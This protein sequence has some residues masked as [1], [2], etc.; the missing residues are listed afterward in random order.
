MR[1]NLSILPSQLMNDRITYIHEQI[2]RKENRI[3]TEEK[4]STSEL[5]LESGQAVWH[6]DPQTKNWNSGW[7]IEKSKEPNSFHIESKEGATY[8]RNQNFLKPRQVPHLDT[9][10]NDYSNLG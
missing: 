8:R 3:L 6:Q 9:T 4:N 5:E 1:S 7:I 10:K 2:T